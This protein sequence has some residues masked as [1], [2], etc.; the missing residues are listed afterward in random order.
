LQLEEEEEEEELVVA[1]KH[2]ETHADDGL[3]FQ[4]ILKWRC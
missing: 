3:G 2:D 4:S 1:G